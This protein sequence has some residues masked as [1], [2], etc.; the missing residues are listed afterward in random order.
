MKKFLFA[1]ALLIVLSAIAFAAEPGYFIAPS[2]EEG[3]VADATIGCRL[4][5]T[6]TYLRVTSTG[7]LNEG[8]VGDPYFVMNTE[9]D[10]KYEWI[11]LRIKNLSDAPVFEFHFASTATGDKVTASSCT[12]FPIST[13]DSSYKEYIFNIKE[14]NLASQNIN[15]DVKLE[16][17]T[18]DGTVSQVRFDCMWIAEPSGQVPKGSV[19][20]IDYIGFFETKEDAE[21]FVPPAKVVKNNADYSGVEWDKN[22]PHFI[23]SDESES[24]NWLA[25]SSS[26]AYELG[27]LRLTPTGIDPT[28]TR[29]FEEPFKAE[30]YPYFA[31]RYKAITEI[32]QGGFFFTNQ[33]QPKLSDATY[34]EFDI[35]YPGEWTNLVMDMRTM[36]HGNWKGDI[37][38]MRLDPVNSSSA[39]MAAIIYINRLG[40]FK[41]EEEAY[42]FLHEGSSEDFS[43]SAEFR[44]YMYKALIPGGSLYEGY[45]KDDFILSSIT[46]EGEG[47]SAPVVYRTEADGT[48]SL[49]ALGY[50]NENGYTSYVANKA[51]EYTLGYNHKDYTDI[52]GH[53]GE[54]YINFVSDRALFGGTSPTEFSPD[55]T[56]TRGM[57]IT[58][59]G[60]MHGLDT[61]KYDGNTGYGDVPATEY[62]APYIQWAKKKG[63][64]AGLS[65]VTFAPEDPITRATMAVVIKNYVDNSGFKFTI[66]SETE[67]FNDLAGLDE[68]TVN[69]INTVKNVGIVGGKGE[70]RFDPNGI[71][72]RA[73]VATVMERVI[74]AVLGV[75]V[76]AGAYTNEYIAR[77]RIRLGVW[78]FTSALGTPEGMKDLRDLGIDLIVHG[79]G[80]STGDVVLNY[81]DVYGIEVYMHDYYTLN[82]SPKDVDKFIENT[83]PKVVSAGYSHHPS[84]SGHYITDEPGTDYFAALGKVVDDYE[85]QMPGKR[86]FINLLP[87]YANA[88]Q[89]KY[90]ASAAAIEY[91]DADPDLYRKHCQEWFNSTATDYICTDIYPLNWTGAMKTTYNNYVESI[92]QIAS[93]AREAGKEF[94]C[95][96]QTYGWQANKRT[97]DESEY[98][99]QCYCMLSFGCTGILLWQYYSSNPQ[100][101]SLV[102]NM[103]LEPTQAYYD[104]QPVM[105]EMRNLSDTYIQYKYLGTYTLNATKPYQKMTN[106]YT[107]FDGITVESDS[108]LLVGCFEQKDGSGAKAMTIVNMEEFEESLAVSANLKVDPA[109]KVTVY[110]RAEPKV[111][112]HNGEIELWLNCGDGLFITIE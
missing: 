77:D 106:E 22:S 99:W 102:D 95:C 90:G 73:E 70:G 33:Y 97:P 45:K 17:S 53:W 112:E 69:A 67:G 49:V 43:T 15:N 76:P 83:D 50:T 40:F 74:K 5:V 31:Y 36:K 92:N 100:F 39:D 7:D 41:S 12:H 103:T 61:S 72:T 1:I 32:N 25:S 89:L 58:V 91:Y 66:Y 63:I 108:A 93:V 57:F 34:S 98:R 42:A 2:A 88:A 18:W 109:K 28:L 6:D 101:P 16:N 86:A 111:V 71:S 23:T 64:M 82:A 29:E 80:G 59:L 4:I 24:D 68:A 35:M 107:G 84:F 11:K 38:L 3:F 81:A 75:N 52:A 26:V 8:S 10:S 47:T 37:N 85:A 104:C 55:M 20:E 54:G 87:M 96:I 62:Y 110:N 56:M 105:W 79:P 9:L 13:K 65:D 51:G 44:G 94:W 14:H 78:N 27:N 30:E 60:R 48:K 46:P 21:G 19:M